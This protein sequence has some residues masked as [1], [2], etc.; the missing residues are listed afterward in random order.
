MRSKTSLVVSTCR[1]VLK[2]MSIK[3]NFLGLLFAFLLCLL[4]FRDAKGGF[5]LPTVYQAHFWLSKQGSNS[6]RL[7]SMAQTT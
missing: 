4:A 1:P 3:F 5:G 6:V 7:L 2:H